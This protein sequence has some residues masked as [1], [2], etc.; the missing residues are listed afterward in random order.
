MSKKVQLNTTLNSDNFQKLK[1]SIEKQFKSKR[2]IG[3]IIV[4]PIYEEELNQYF[5]KTTEWMNR[6]K[7]V[8]KEDPLY[9]VA[10][11]RFGCKVYDSKF[12]PHLDDYLLSEG[13][14]KNYD[15]RLIQI[16]LFK[17]L[18]KYDKAALSQS[19]IVNTILMHGLVSDHYSKHLFDYLYRFY[20]LNL[21]R[22]IQQNDFS[23][24]VNQL[25]GCIMGDDGVESGGNREY[26]LNKQ[27]KDA[28][29]VSSKRS[30]AMKFRW[31][32][33]Y[34]DLYWRTD[35]LPTHS[36]SRLIKLLCNWLEESEIQEDIASY[37]GDRRITEDRVTIPYASYNY[38]TSELKLIIPSLNIDSQSSRVY[39]T[40]LSEGVELQQINLEQTKK[41][42]ITLTNETI[43]DLSKSLLFKEL[44]VKI[45]TDEMDLRNYKVFNGQEI[46]F[47]NSKGISARVSNSKDYYLKEGEYS[48]LSLTSNLKSKAILG[49]F[50][51][52]QL[53]YTEYSFDV[54]DYV[55]Y[56]NHIT[57]IRDK[58]HEDLTK[59]ARVKDVTSNGLEVYSSP[60]SLILKSESKHIC[61]IKVEVNHKKFFYEDLSII[62]L[63]E[64][65]AR[66]NIYLIELESILDIGE[67]L[68]IMD[69]PAK[70]NKHFQFTLLP[71]TKFE[72]LDAPY[73][74]KET[75]KIIF[76]TN[77]VRGNYAIVDK[78]EGYK[79]YEFEINDST[80]DLSFEYCT[81]RN[82][83][84]LSVKVPSFKWGTSE[85]KMSVAS[86]DQI[87]HADFNYRLFI[88][89]PDKFSFVAC[90]GEDCS[91]PIDV[92]GHE[93]KVKL[94][95]LT[96]LKSLILSQEHDEIVS[97]IYI[98]YKGERFRF[99][100][101]FRK[102][103]I[104][105][106]SVLEYD[107]IENEIKFRI[108]Y[109]GKD[110][111][112]L[113]LK[114]VSENDY[115]ETKKELITDEVRVGS[116]GKSGLYELVI[117]KREK[118][119]LSKYEEI[120][121]ITT[122]LITDNITGLD[123]ELLNHRY[124]EKRINLVKYST[125]YLIRDVQKI[126]DE[127][128]LANLYSL[129]YRQSISE[130]GRIS[131]R[132]VEWQ[133]FSDIIFEVIDRERHIT[134]QISQ[135]DDPEDF[136]DTVSIIYDSVLNKF[137]YEEEKMPVRQRY[138]RY[139]DLGEAKFEC[140]LYDGGTK[141]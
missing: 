56:E 93:D 89:F 111:L 101:V 120:Y 127:R 128:Y 110:K 82:I 32:L 78:I 138:R 68:V 137:V 134:L 123:L 74:F 126:E 105:S 14:I 103:V 1:K 36:K 59:N 43:I 3:D 71:G 27:V 66:H 112:F 2:L 24:L 11:I 73:I 23:L 90:V 41:T 91:N 49:S 94:V 39:A 55:V 29:K 136:N 15:R 46:V 133:K 35:F 4:N 13:E 54:N 9:V 16:K 79:V 106:T 67:N 80:M 58:Y 132:V 65:S 87:W 12:W 37:S 21:H 99:A 81:E 38:H 122:K 5:I 117:Y 33:K 31:I 52:G 63:N 125:R 104:L 115:L 118:S 42:Y 83:F 7:D 34:I 22:N 108:N 40:I 77:Q 61:G 98:E 44:V 53:Y 130:N 72:F 96:K 50:K 102:T 107:E 51:I 69:L 100:E 76:E 47:F 62:K 70:P 48:S 129:G 140:S 45:H 92:Y 121:R 109:V 10:L 64:V 18:K 8:G 86:L 88:S 141:S 57:W 6:Y 20:K 75:G 124:F 95:D 25:V 119:F 17:T 131:R 26:M 135:L 84:P 85:N 19:E 30:T 114:L 97:I 139:K 28:I 113:D 60:P 116:D